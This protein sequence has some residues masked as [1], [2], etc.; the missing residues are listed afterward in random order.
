MSVSASCPGQRAAAPP[1]RVPLPWSGGPWACRRLAGPGGF[2]LLEILLAIFVFSLVISMIAMTMGRSM[3]LANDIEQQAEL[4]AMARTTLLRIQ[5][6]IE[7]IPPLPSATSTEHGPVSRRQFVLPDRTMADDEQQSTVVQFIS[8]ADVPA[9]GTPPLRPH[10]SLI[11][12]ETQKEEDTTLTLFR[13]ATP[14]TMGPQ[15]ST[16]DRAILCELLVGIDFQ[17][18]DRAGQ[19]HANWDTDANPDAGLP[20]RVTVTLRFRDPSEESGESRFMT[21]FLIPV[22]PHR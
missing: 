3:T 9:A 1:H 13:T 10:R 14:L 19:E 8:T 18:T 22:R 11:T 15:P 7:A 2:T 20:Q 5:E 6:E 12:Y 17:V 16:G 4:Y 21:S